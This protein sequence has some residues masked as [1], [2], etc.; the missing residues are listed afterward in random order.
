MSLDTLYNYAV[1]QCSISSACA[2]SYNYEA[3]FLMRTVDYYYL[4]I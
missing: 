1:L 4:H 3:V 2:R